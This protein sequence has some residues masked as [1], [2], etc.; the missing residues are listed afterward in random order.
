ME[1][2]VYEA[3]RSQLPSTAKIYRRSKIPKR[4]RLSHSKRVAPLVVIPEPGTVISNKERW[5]RAEREGTLDEIRGGH[6]YDN[7]NP[8]LRATFIANGPAF[9]NGFVSEPFESVDVYNLMAKILKL[10]PAKNDGKWK[11]IKNVLR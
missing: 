4:F 7:M 5:A 6:G 2:K 11:R 9:K 10:K 3:I 1:D 8:L